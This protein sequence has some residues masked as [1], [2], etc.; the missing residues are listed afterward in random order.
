[1]VEITSVDAV[2]PGYQVAY[3]Q[4]ICFYQYVDVV[5]HE[6]VAVDHIFVF[7]MFHGFF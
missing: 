7:E 3:V 5:V 2:H 1:M 4:V 6:A